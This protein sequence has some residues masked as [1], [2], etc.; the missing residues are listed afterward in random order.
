MG[1]G[2][3]A[4]DVAQRTAAASERLQQ[5]AQG[6]ARMSKAFS[7]GAE[8][9]E[10]L[11]SALAPL[12]ARGWLALPDRQAPQGGNLDLIVV[13]PPGVAVIDAKNWSFPVTL[14]EGN[15]YTGR[16]RRP[17]AIDGV[18]RQVEVVQAALAEI[19]YPVTVRGVLALAGELDRGRVSEVARDVQIVG[20]DHLENEFAQMKRRLSTAHI[21]EVFR[22][23]SLE[24]PSQE[25]SNAG[26]PA[27]MS[28]LSDPV[29]VH[30]LFDKNTRFFYIREWNRSGKSRLYLKSSNGVD[31]GWKNVN[32]GEV[33]LTCE[34]DEAKLVQAVLA[35]AS[36]TG[37]T[38][39]SQDVPKIV[40][41]MPGGK[42]LSRLIS[43]WALVL[44]GQEWS[45]RGAHRLYGTLIVPGT[46][47]F[48]LGHADL[49][50]GELRPAVD[51]KLGKDLGSAEKYL[52]LLVER[53]PRGSGSHAN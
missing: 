9:E 48:S 11:A 37:I 15:I 3:S 51:G 10:A 25:T 47:T 30:K 4:R 32:T 5:R 39:S 38:L 49:K 20:I 19:A 35:K 2:E 44:V 46:G 13:G 53:Q 45:A 1:A 18:L 8:G 6:A 17:K 29:K 22:L 7:V 41:D 23:L 16:Y 31:L 24:F 36:P 33:Q 28:V 21:E 27:T 43:L 40:L 12:A 52:Q 26:N 42:L 14:K 50:T 34:D